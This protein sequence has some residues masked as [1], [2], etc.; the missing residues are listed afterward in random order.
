MKNT[1]ILVFTAYEI[2]NHY[3]NQVTLLWLACPLV[4]VFLAD[5]ELPL[6]V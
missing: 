6:R 2:I 3:Y 5:A 1:E 4:A